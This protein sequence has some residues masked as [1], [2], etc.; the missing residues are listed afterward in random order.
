MKRT[1]MK[2]T[3]KVVQIHHRQHLLSASPY[4]NQKA[5]LEIYDDDDD[6]IDQKGN[7]W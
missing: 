6:V 5:P 2:P 1:Y 3:T 4:D 7:I